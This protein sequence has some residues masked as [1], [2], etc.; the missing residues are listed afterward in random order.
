[1]KRLV[2]SVLMFG[3]AVA[4][5]IAVSAASE[6]QVTP[7]IPGDKNCAG[8]TMAYLAQGNDAVPGPGIGNVADQASLTVKELKAI[9]E[10]YCA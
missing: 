3:A 2:L 1:M 5:P 10:A 4:T 8:Q 7:G 9:V 6:N